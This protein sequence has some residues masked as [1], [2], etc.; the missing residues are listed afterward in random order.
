MKTNV[1]QQLLSLF[2]KNASHLKKIYVA[3]I[4]IP[5]SKSLARWPNFLS[6]VI[7]K[8]WHLL[9]FQ[10]RVINFWER[11]L[12]VLKF[13]NVDKLSIFTFV[14]VRIRI[15]LHSKIQ[16]RTSLIRAMKTMFFSVLIVIIKLFAIQSLFDYSLW[17]DSE[18]VLR[19]QKV[20]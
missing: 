18:K 8:Y 2:M 19:L 14:Y 13:T 17:N 5:F 10:I 20:W 16:I 11:S 12:K 6:T 15:C 3:L 7:L 4:N 9:F 1:F